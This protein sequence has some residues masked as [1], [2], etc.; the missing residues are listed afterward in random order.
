MALADSNAGFTRAELRGLFQH[1]NGNLFHYATSENGWNPQLAEDFPHLVI[2][3]D[4]H[5]PV[6]YAKVLKTVAHVVVDEAD[7]GSPVVEKWDI[8]HDRHGLWRDA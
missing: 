3:G 1:A 8:T 6:R 4:I 2:V 5:N 7:D